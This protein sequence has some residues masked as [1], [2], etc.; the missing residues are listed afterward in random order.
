MREEDNRGTVTV[1]EGASGNI[2]E[3][4]EFRDIIRGGGVHIHQLAA[5]LAWIDRV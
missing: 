2:M 1:E 4:I 5:A 3:L